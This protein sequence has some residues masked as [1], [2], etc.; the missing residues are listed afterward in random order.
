MALKFLDLKGEWEE[1]KG[2]W[3]GVEKKEGEGKEVE[4]KEDG[5][6]K[7]R[8]ESFGEDEDGKRSGEKENVSTPL[9]KVSPPLVSPVTLDLKDEEMTDHATA[10][11]A[12]RPG[13][14]TTTNSLKLNQANPKTKA[15]YSR[16]TST[17]TEMPRPM[18]CAGT[19]RPP[20]T[21]ATSPAWL[22]H[23]L[24]RPSHRGVPHVF[25]ALLLEQRGRG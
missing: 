8:F 25:P 2:E 16:Q 7:E 6:R 17:P 22:P 12:A 15:G 9:E 23:P 21:C 14:P 19:G 20:P 13:S 24:L 1:G 18:M 4:K 3:K 5:H 10:L 11:E